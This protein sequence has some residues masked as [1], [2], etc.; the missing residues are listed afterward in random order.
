MRLAV[1]TDHRGVALKD[2]LV[3][4]LREAGHEVDDLGSHG[5]ASVDYPDFAIAVAER[6]AAGRAERGVLVCGTGI[7]MSIAA[8]K[9][10]GARAALVYDEDAVRLSREHNDANILVLPGN[11]LESGRACE[12]LRLWLA[13]PFAGGRHERRVGRITNYERDRQDEPRG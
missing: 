10:Q 7:G 13:T 4:C 2:A 6:V 11:W 5:A 9:V 12:W 8:N 1:A 3:A